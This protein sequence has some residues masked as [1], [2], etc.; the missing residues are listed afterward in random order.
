[1]PAVILHIGDANQLCLLDIS[2]LQSDLLGVVGPCMLIS[3]GPV[4]P[5]VNSA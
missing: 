3:H 4:S 5:Q 2:S 1:M